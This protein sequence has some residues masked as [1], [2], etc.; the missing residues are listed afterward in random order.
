MYWKNVDP[1]DKSQ[2]CDKGESYKSVIFYKTDSQ[3]NNQCFNKRIEKKFN[4]KVVTN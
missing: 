4:K 1:F 2:F 3:K